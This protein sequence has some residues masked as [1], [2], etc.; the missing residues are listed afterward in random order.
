M[1]DTFSHEPAHTKI[2]MQKR[3][4]ISEARPALP[5]TPFFFALSVNIGDTFSLEIFFLHAK[6]ALK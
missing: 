1:P 4:E 6:I 2:M 5:A 3:K